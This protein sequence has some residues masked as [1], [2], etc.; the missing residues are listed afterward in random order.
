MSRTLKI[1]QIP[2]RS[3]VNSLSE[4]WATMLAGFDAYIWEHCIAMEESFRA[5]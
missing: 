3:C 1:G 4:K 2:G 5:D